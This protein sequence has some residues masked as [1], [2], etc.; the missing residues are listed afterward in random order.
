V[1]I[2][3]VGGYGRSGSTLVGRVLGGLPDTVCVGETR[4]LWSRGLLDNVECGCGAPFRSCPFWSAV[5][6]EAFGGWSRVDAERLTEVDRVTNLL[7]TLPFYWMPWLRPA[8]TDT[9]GDYAA[10]L[11]ALYAAIS[12]VSGAKTIIEI[13]K[14][15]TFACLLMRMPRSDVHIL[16]LV[17]DSRAVAYS[18]T[19]RRREPSPIG[20]QQFMGQFSPTH[21][22]KSWVTWNAA[23]HALSA[24]RSPYLKLT[25]ESFVA[26]PRG[27]LHKLSA[28]ANEALV[29]PASQLTDT[30]VKLGDHHIFSGNP[31]RATTGW[32]PI[33]LDNE[34]QTQLSTAQ[35]AKVTAI[36]WPL[37]CLYGY[38]IVPAARSSGR[39]Q[40]GRR[41]AGLTD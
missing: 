27:V 26:D 41:P 29:L 20:G 8:L 1:K 36:T 10:R 19:R 4:Y 30:E 35:L 21:T 33:R 39:R 31:M 3:Y 34:W 40:G 9:I 23:F 17:R 7:A 5:G 2:L 14:D 18:W 11:S 24:A 28:F 22:A 15:P 13:S 16:H 25:Y 38:P 6:D 37:L 12:R 32:L